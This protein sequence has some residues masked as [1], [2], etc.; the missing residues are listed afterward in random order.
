MEKPLEG[1]RPLEYEATDDLVAELMT[2]FDD[3]VLLVDGEPIK[4]QDRFT[5]YKAGNNYLPL[6][7]NAVRFFKSLKS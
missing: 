5:I 4:G 2:R 6:C 3:L 7:R 1:P